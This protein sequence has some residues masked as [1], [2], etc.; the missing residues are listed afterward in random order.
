MAQQGVLDRARSDQLIANSVI[1]ED[2][3]REAVP[4]NIRRAEHFIAFLRRFVE[5]L[6]QR[7]RGGSVEQG[8]ADCV[9]GAPSADGGD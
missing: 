8:D 9:F 6:K 4:G 7:M 3:L 5:Y 2:I 1:S